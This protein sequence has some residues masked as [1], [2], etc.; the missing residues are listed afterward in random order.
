MNMATLTQQ[1]DELKEQFAANLAATTNVGESVA[2]LSPAIAEEVAQLAVVL[3]RLE[4]KIEEL[5]ANHPT[6]EDLA[7]ITSLKQMS[8]EVSAGL[9]GIVDKVNQVTAE[10]ENIVTPAPV[11]EEPVV[12]EPVVEEPIVEEPVVEEPIVEEPVVEEP[13]VE[14][15]IVEEPVVV[16][17]EPPAPFDPF[18]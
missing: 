9:N 17:E 13:V 8:Q 12:E 3:G 18:N 7:M 5:A 11:V 16:P 10:V 2:K 6:P 4:S 15:P 14:E 1:L